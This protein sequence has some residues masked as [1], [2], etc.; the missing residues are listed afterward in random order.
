MGRRISKTFSQAKH[1]NQ[2]PKETCKMG[3]KKE[4]KLARMQVCHHQWVSIDNHR[5]HK[6]ENKTN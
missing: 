2:I 6:N 5:S 3:E 4:A 1:P